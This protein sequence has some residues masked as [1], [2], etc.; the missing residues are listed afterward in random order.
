MKPLSQR[1]Q[2]IPPSATVA[3]SDRARQLRAEGRDVIALAGGDPDFPTPR[4]IM[5]AAIAAMLAGETNY[6]PARGKPALI[7]A[8]AAK[9]ERENGVRVTANQVIVTPGGK[10]SLYIAVTALVNAGDEV[11]ILDPSWVSYAPIVTL[12]GA[13]PVH[14]RLPNEENFRVSEELLRAAITER[15]KLLIVNSPNNP[16]GRVLTRAEIDAIVRVATEYDLYVVSDEIYEHLV[17]DGAVHYSLAAQPGMAERTITVNGFSKAY[18][19]TGWRLGWLAAPEPVSR[20]ALKLQTQSVTSAASFAMAGGVAALTGLQ[21]CVHEMVAADAERRRFMLDALNAIP[22]IECTPIEGAFYLFPRFPRTRKNSL[23]L[24]EAL[25][26]Q[27]NIAATPG[28]AFG[29]AGAGHLRFSIA[30]GMRELER[31][32]ERLAKVAPAL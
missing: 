9:L 13:T 16:T 4:H 23:E 29:E 18:A 27:A 1:L 12:N 22:G 8:I 2:S 14:V 17:F 5:D 21:D 10:W 26:E 3:V 6:P 25:L 19:M 7:E 20:L 24:A 11:L 28:I 30:T 32:V 15:T 31:A